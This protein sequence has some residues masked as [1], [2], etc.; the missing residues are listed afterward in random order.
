MKQKHYKDEHGRKETS[1]YIPIW[2]EL[3]I[4]NTGRATF[5]IDSIFLHATPAKS[6]DPR[7]LKYL[8]YDL[9]Q[10]SH[11]N[12]VPP[13]IKIMLPIVVEPGH[14]K[15]MLSKFDLMIHEVL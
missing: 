10:P 13:E 15:I 11:N 5:S 3:K 1:F 4:A 8:N 7:Q 6:M 14:S 2:L 12:E 9:F